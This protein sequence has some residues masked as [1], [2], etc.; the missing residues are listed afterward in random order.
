MRH[1]LARSYLVLFGGIG[2]VSCLL[3]YLSLSHL[4]WMFAIFRMEDRIHAILQDDPGYPVAAQGERRGPPPVG[5]I[6]LPESIPSLEQ[7]PLERFN[8]P[9]LSAALLDSRGDILK[10]S[11]NFQESTASAD[12]CQLADLAQRTRRVL[13]GQ[14]VLAPGPGHHKMRLSWADGS[15]G[16]VLVAPVSRGEE[17]LGFLLLRSWRGPEHRLIERFLWALAL[18]LLGTLAATVWLSHALARRWSRPLEELAAAAQRVAKGDFSA[19]TGLAPNSTEIYDV[20]VTFDSMVAGLQAQFDTQRRF[21]S[22]ASHELKTPLAAL[23]GQIHIV[24]LLEE[25]DPNPRR[26]RAIA[27]MERD[28]WRMDRLVRDLLTLSRAEQTSVAA[29]PFLLQDLLDEAVDSALAAF[30]GRTIDTPP[31]QTCRLAGEEEALLGALRNLLDNALQHTSP[32]QTVALQVSLDSDF[33]KLTVKDEGCGVAAQ[34]IP[35]LTQRFY[36]VDQGRARSEG[37]SGLGLSIVKAVAEKHGGRLE[38][39]SEIGVGTQAT[40][41][42]PARLRQV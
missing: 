30:P 10:K 35:Q 1:I 3:L 39:V 36:R 32:S 34:H 31:T 4:L 23:E 11:A 42:L 38:I 21:V 33:V 17:L 13:S 29:T 8:F 41:W 7:V 25:D 28:L 6:R 18:G 20:S 9:F 16:Q 24:T 14:E 12:P 26:G 27:A 22:D 5:P 19:R 2:L 15:D 40:L 37:G